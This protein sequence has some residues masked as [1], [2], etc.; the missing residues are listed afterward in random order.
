M[1]SLKSPATTREP[2]VPVVVFVE[3]AVRWALKEIATR[4]RLTVSDML[5]VKIN[6]I[7]GE[8]AARAPESED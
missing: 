3:P 1:N 4:R 5:R 7:I 2:L 8:G 6:Q